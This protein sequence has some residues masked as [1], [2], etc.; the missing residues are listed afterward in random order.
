VRRVLDHVA[1]QCMRLDP[2]ADWRAPAGNLLRHE[3]ALLTAYAQRGLSATDWPH[4]G[5]ASDTIVAVLAALYSSP[6]DPQIGG[7]VLDHL[8]SDAET[9]DPMSLVLL[10]A[11][12]RM[13]VAGRGTVP[14]RALAALAGLDPR[15]LRLLGQRGEIDVRDGRVPC[16]E[17]RRWLGARGIEGIAEA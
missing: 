6:G 11:Y 4:H 1:T 7:G 2:G 5:C 8:E 13:T 15:H 9:D 17:A 14:L 3:V 10:A 12:A 16:A